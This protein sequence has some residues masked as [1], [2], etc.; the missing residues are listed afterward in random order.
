[1]LF[2]CERDKHNNFNYNPVQECV[3]Y[4]RTI[5]CSSTVFF[6][7]VTYRPGGLVPVAN[8]LR[9]PIRTPCVFIK[10]TNINLH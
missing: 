10:S 1:M 5:K 2:Q 7:Y 8:T 6:L 4:E 9:F 3:F